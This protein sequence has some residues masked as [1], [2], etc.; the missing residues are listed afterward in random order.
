[1][2]QMWIEGGW[3]MFPVLVFGLIT[4]F[5]A[6]RYAIDGQT[7]RLRFVA[8]MSGVLVVSM[9]HSMLTNVA[10]VFSFLQD[11][12]RAPDADFSRILCTG[13][14]ES[15]RPGAL[16][17]ALLVLTLVL[18]AVGVYRAGQKELRLAAA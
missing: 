13:L 15:T 16:G 9:A 8:A 12:A 2:M 3:G 14:M 5:A 7:P 11:P 4:M 18:V 17:G 6:G 1:M 10:A